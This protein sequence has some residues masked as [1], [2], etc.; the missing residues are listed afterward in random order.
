MINKIKNELL[1]LG[2]KFISNDEKLIRIFLETIPSNINEI[3]II[4]TVKLVMKKLINKLASKNKKGQVYNGLL[5]EVRVS[6]I[7]CHIGCPNMAILMECLKR[8]KAKK[9]IRIDICGGITELKNL[10]DVGNIIIP[11]KAYCGDGTTTQYILTHPDL[12]NQLDSIENPIGRFENIIAGNQKI[13]ISKPD[14]QLS[15][16]LFNHGISDI[17]SI[18]KKVDLWTTDALFCETYDFLNAWKAT[19]IECIDMESSILFLLGKLYN[20][21]TSSIL[22]VSDLPGTK[23]DFLNSNEIHPNMENGIN[24][25]V[26]IL[27]NSLSKIK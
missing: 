9:I 12:A 19:N 23:Y 3:V 6:I 2:L 14:E 17:S 16:I 24:K 21:K 8:T 27:M 13:Y 5:N 7:R 20:L 22:A 25:A 15:N 26:R 4:P 11:K 1:N 18:T 10:I